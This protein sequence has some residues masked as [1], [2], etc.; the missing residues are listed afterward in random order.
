MARVVRRD[1]HGALLRR[2]AQSSASKLIG[3]SRPALSPLRILAQV[4][5]RSILRIADQAVAL[6]SG[7]QRVLDVVL[8]GTPAPLPIGSGQRRLGTAGR[9]ARGPGLAARP[10]VAEAAPCRRHQ[11]QRRQA[12]GD[13]RLLLVGASRRPLWQAACRDSMASAVHSMPLGT[14]PCARAHVSVS[15]QFSR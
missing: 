12:E 4:C 10:G 1:A 8:I 13:Q 5:R 11:H 15:N 6:G 3:S 2:G 7:V 9:R 14:A